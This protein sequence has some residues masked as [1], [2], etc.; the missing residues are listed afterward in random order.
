MLNES[1][2]DEC[3][4]LFANTLPIGENQSKK[5]VEAFGEDV[6]KLL[7]ELFGKLG[8][9]CS[10]YPEEFDGYLD[11]IKNMIA[12]MRDETDTNPIEYLDMVNEEQEK[13]KK[14]MEIQLGRYKSEKP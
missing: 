2:V 1:R 7:P 5:L 3:F 6:S 4:W 11:L 10:Q 12:Y 14:H 13:L 8:S 9:V